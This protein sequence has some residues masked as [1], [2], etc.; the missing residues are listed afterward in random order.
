MGPGVHGD[1][2]SLIGSFFGTFG[3]HHQD[4]GPMAFL[5]TLTLNRNAWAARRSSP[6]LGKNTWAFGKQQWSWLFWSTNT[7]SIGPLFAGAVASICPM[8]TIWWVLSWY[9]L[10]S[11]KHLHLIF[12]IHHVVHLHCEQ[13]ALSILEPSAFENWEMLHHQ[14]LHFRFLTH[15]CLDLFT[16]RL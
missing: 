8:S 3:A 10:Q 9:M 6:E 11:A 5:E 4:H 13:L 1:T 15:R 2:W 14:W 16:Y 7:S 12:N